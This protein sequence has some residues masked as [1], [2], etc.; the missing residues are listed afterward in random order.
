[1]SVNRLLGEGGWDRPFFKLL[2][3]NDT[4]AAKGHQGGMVI[5]L[6]LVPYFPGIVGK[7]SKAQP[8]LDTQ[9]QGRLYN[10]EAFL[11][12]VA[13]RFQIQTWGGTRSPEHRLTENLGP[14][15]NL[16]DQDDLL[17]MQRRTDELHSYR[18]I[19]VPQTHPEYGDLVAGVGKA[20]WGV[21]KD[22]APVSQSD[23]SAAEEREK[24]HEAAPFELFET[25]PPTVDSRATRIAR[26]IVFR[27]EVAK[28]YGGTCCACGEA[29]KH[30]HGKMELNGSH[31]VPRHLAGA[32]DV[33]NGLALCLRH[34]WAFDQG[35]IAIDKNRRFIVSKVASGLAENSPLS[36][37]AG[38]PLREAAPPSKR[39]ADE[40][41]AWHRENVFL[42]GP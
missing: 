30:P 5:P 4:G 19:L 17:I 2:A 29:L 10:G 32:D 25:D 18:L 6:D 35:L 42:A 14:L 36:D 39:A 37:L 1:M 7:A 40:A 11:A 8:T 31:I 27:R 13:T 26:S 20:R 34:H 28:A 41:L 23:L 15:R 16:A 33:R 12:D 24:E 9:I 21:L 3:K 38:S 22:S